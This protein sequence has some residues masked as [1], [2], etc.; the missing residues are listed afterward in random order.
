MKKIIIKI[1]IGSL[2]IISSL[3]AVYFFINHKDNAFIFPILNQP[4][5]WGSSRDDIIELV[6]VNTDSSD[7]QTSTQILYTNEKIE[8]LFGSS[9]ETQFYINTDSAFPVGL[10]GVQFKLDNS[11]YEETKKALFKQYGNME[12]NAVAWESSGKVL[13]TFYY[14]ESSRFIDMDDSQWDVLYDY[15]TKVSNSSTQEELE[16]RLSKMREE[17]YFFMIQVTEPNVIFINALPLAILSN[18]N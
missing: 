2:V 11:T 1:I 17:E 12:E 6:N 14:P 10:Y 8:T 13:T 16:Y 4:L 9:S 3:L 18:S 5:K 7:N 15:Y